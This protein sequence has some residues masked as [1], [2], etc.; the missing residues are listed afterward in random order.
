MVSY[1]G[2]SMIAS[3][4]TA[5]LLVRAAREIHTDDPLT[6]PLPSRSRLRLLNQPFANK[7]D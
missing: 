2:S 7:Q 5:A 4:V 1:G 6:L 3:L